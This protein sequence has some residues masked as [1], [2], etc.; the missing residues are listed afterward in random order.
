MAQENTWEFH[1][2]QIIASLML[3]NRKLYEELA[4]QV[5]LEP[6][7]LFPAYFYNLS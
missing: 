7:H 4:F 1:S 5:G 2:K 3:N 6:D